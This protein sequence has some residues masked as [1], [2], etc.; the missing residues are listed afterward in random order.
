MEWG[1]GEKAKSISGNVDLWS[2]VFSS[3]FFFSLFFSLVLFFWGGAGEDI[4]GLLLLLILSFDL[5]SDD[6]KRLRY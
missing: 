1:D 3:V 5:G 2:G 6:G 4:L